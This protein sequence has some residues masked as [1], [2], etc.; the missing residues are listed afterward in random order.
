L[1][2]P[3]PFFFNGKKELM[4]LQPDPKFAHEQRV[5]LTD[6][7]AEE[8][9]GSCCVTIAAAARWDKESQ[10]WTYQLRLSNGNLHKDG[11]YIAEK[12]LNLKQKD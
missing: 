1:Y 8:G 9:D 2:T 12:W 3:S 7:D 6:E 10:Q 5:W 4:R 11:E